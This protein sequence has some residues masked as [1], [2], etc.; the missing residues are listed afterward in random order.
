M[1]LRSTRDSALDSQGAAEGSHRARWISQGAII[2]AFKW[3]GRTGVQ[4]SVTSRGQDLRDHQAL[5]G[6]QLGSGLMPAHLCPL[7]DRQFLFEPRPDVW[8]RGLGP[9]AGTI[10]RGGLLDAS[11]RLVVEFPV[12]AGPANRRSAGA[13]GKAATGAFPAGA[14]PAAS[15]RDPPRPLDALDAT[16]PRRPGDGA[17][18]GRLADPNKAPS[19]SRSHHANDAPHAHGPPCSTCIALCGLITVHN[20]ADPPH[21]DCSHNLVHTA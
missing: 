10:E 4:D 19:P 6:D 7:L 15:L 12:D 18:A 3:P 8:G 20:A 21:A 5:S 2:R 16:A 1:T 13:G 9:E 11:E 17:H 14:V